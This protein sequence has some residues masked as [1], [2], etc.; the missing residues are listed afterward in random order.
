MLDLGDDSG[1]NDYVPEHRRP[2]PFSR[3]VFI[4]DGA[5]DIPCFSIVRRR[6]GFALAVFA[7]EALADSH[8][9]ITGL[10]NDQRIDGVGGGDF[11]AGATL[12][13]LFIRVVDGIKARSGAERGGPAAADRQNG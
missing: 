5:T 12:E 13:K 1:I 8:D 3:I 4:G 7:T 10:I 11:R 9:Q 6:G 2:V